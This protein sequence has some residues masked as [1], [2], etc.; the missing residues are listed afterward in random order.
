[1]TLN[2]ALFTT[3]SVDFHDNLLRKRLTPDSSVIYIFLTFNG[4][5]H[6]LLAPPEYARIRVGVRL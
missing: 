2:E 4:E 5:W 3:F 6:G 1:L